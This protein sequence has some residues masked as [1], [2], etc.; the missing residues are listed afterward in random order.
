MPDGPTLYFQGTAQIAGGLGTVFGDGLQCAGGTTTRLGIEFNVGGAS[1]YPDSGQ[2]AISVQGLIGAPGMRVYQ[3][4]YRS[5]S[6]FCQ[7]AGFSLTNGF[8]ITWT[9]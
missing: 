5:S 9:P 8:Q 6:A 2:P 1:H 7:H 4:W 3:G